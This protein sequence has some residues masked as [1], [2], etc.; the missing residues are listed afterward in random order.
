M[1]DSESVLL[2]LSLLEF[3]SDQ[4][5]VGKLNLDSDSPM[6]LYRLAPLE[7]T[8]N[9]K[10]NQKALLMKLESLGDV[11]TEICLS[12]L[13]SSHDMLTVVV[14]TLK[15]NDPSGKFGQGGILASA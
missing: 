13:I 15:A 1:S 4:I 8:K 11:K 14:T 9:V 10:T 3:T 2:S 5:L 12:N 7:V 6:G